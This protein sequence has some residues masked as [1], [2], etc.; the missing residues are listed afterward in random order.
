MIR[1]ITLILVIINQ[2]AVAIGGMLGAAP[3]LW[4][5]IATVVLTVVTAVWCGWKNNDWTRAAQIGSA[6]MNA[7]KDGQITAEEAQELLEKN[8]EALNDKD[9]SKKNE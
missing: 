1:T 9:T 8:T 4:Y 6:V 7:V 5:L 2:V 3:P